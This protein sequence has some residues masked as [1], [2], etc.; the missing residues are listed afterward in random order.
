VTNNERGTSAVL[1][2]SLAALAALAALSS[3]ALGLVGLTAT[4]AG[5]T[6]PGGSAD[7][8]ADSYLVL[9]QPG[10]DANKEAHGLSAE[11]GLKLGHVYDAV[12]GFSFQGPAQK[13]AALARNPNVALVEQ[14]R[15][16]SITAETVPPAQQTPV[17]VTRVHGGN[18][19]SA[20][21]GTGAVVAVI[22]TGVD[23]DHQDLANL[24]DPTHDAFVRDKTAVE[25]TSMVGSTVLGKDCVSS[26]GKTSFDD[27]HYHGTHV[28]G[29]IAA[30]ANDVGVVGVAPG[31]KIVPVKVLNSAGSGSWTDIVCGIDF[32]A[33]NGPGTSL[34]ISVANMSLGG[35][36]SAGT[37]CSS[38]TMRTAICTAVGNGVAFVVAAGNSGVDASGFVPAAFPEVITVS[39]IDATNFA[40]QTSEPLASFSNFGSVVDVAAP[41]VNVYSTRPDNTYGYLSGTSMAS[42]HAAAIAAIALTQHDGL[43]PAADKGYAS[44]LARFLRTSG[45]CNVVNAGVPVGAGGT[46][47]TP[48]SSERDGYNEPMVDA[49]GAA[50]QPIV[51]PGTAA[52]GG[53]LKANVV[54]AKFWTATVTLSATEAGRPLSGVTVVGN[55]GGLYSATGKSCVTG[56]S[57]TCIV[58][59]PSLD[60]KSQ[61]Q[62]SFTLTSATR[63]G[64]T[65]SLGTIAP[66]SKP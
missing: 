51:A 54:N 52:A 40:A 30:Q 56:S 42:P 48:W 8:I 63:A 43:V 15:I 65:F 53:S 57:G 33:K 41:G 34:N 35:S 6:D 50:T 2:R 26:D 3:G 24:A 60:R 62:E 1:R 13:A 27:D 21:A 49:Q 31:A 17:G 18:V 20:S 29:T 4:P 25:G 28:A 45:T 37:S 32:V 55:W 11:H 46:C 19:A 36:G 44:E 22:D 10:S 7:V 39:A 66:V 61:L 5:A 59:T 9:L 64:Y 47:Q 23:V 38:S 16:M 58:T 14:D 12:G